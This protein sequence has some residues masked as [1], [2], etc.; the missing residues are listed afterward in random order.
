MHSDESKDSVKLRAAELIGKHYGLFSDR[1]E[2]VVLVR[3]SEEI[4]VELPVFRVRLNTALVTYR[5]T[6]SATMFQS[7]SLSI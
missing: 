7:E 3:S 1:I 2:A 5:F 4:Q 6:Y